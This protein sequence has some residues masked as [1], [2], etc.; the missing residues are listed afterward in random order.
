VNK[1]SKSKSDG[2]AYSKNNLVMR[3]YVGMDLH[4]NYLQIAVVDEKGIVLKNSKIENNIKKIGKFFDQIDHSKIKNHDTN[5]TTTKVVMESSCVWYDIYEYLTEEKNLNVKLSNPIKTRAIASAKIKTD[6]LDAVKLANLL[7]GD[8]ISE[9]YVPDKRII[10]LR[11][12]VRH[13]SALVRMRT[14]LKN[15]IH[16]ILLMKGIK[17]T[18][19]HPFSIG[20]IE[21]LKKLNNYRID[22]YIR[23]FTNI[24]DEI[25]IISKNIISFTRQNATT[26]LLMTIPGINYY[27]ALLVMSEIGD[28]N[29]F[30]DSSHLCSYAGLVPSTHSSGGITHHGPITKTGSKYLRWIMIECTRS[31]VRYNKI[32][33]VTTF[34]NKLVK[35]KGS[36]SKAIV[37]ASSKLLKI[38][39]WVM[40]ENIEYN[41]N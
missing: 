15:K 7:R 1:I 12:L 16:G 25:R 14:K 8:Y 13:R 34:Y 33:N 4:K 41:Y 40:K 9:C 39:Y 18:D 28:I 27:S 5:R 2:K 30:P 26:K 29:R 20:Y 37:A 6:K 31:H 17:I 22:T 19:H 11:E 35:N 23:I 3:R 21:Q 32:S 10:E 24:D 38:V 36:S